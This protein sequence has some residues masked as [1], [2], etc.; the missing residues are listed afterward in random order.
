MLR[1]GP[2]KVVVWTFFFDAKL[3]RSEGRRVPRELSVKAPSLREVAEAARRAGYRVDVDEKSRHPAHWFDYA[4]R[5]LVYT[6][7][8]KTAVIR[9]IAGEL[10]KLRSSA[11]KRR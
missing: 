5:V 3:S 10:V 9:K 7:E 6:E 4:G 2:R 11:K 1:R 8:P